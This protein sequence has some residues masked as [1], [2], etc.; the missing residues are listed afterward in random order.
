M[1]KQSILEMIKDREAQ[2]DIEKPILTAADQALM[3]NMI[4]EINEAVG[5]YFRGYSDV[6]DQYIQGAGEIVAKYIFRFED[7]GTRASLLHHLVG[8][9]TYS[10]KPVKDAVEIVWQ[11]YTAYRNSEEFAVW[12]IRMEYDDAFARLRAKKLADRLIESVRN[13]LEFNAL[14]RTVKMLATLMRPELEEILLDALADPGKMEKYLK[15][16]AVREQ[17]RL[18]QQQVEKECRRWSTTSVLKAVVGIRYYPSERALD[19]LRLY[20]SGKQAEMQ[21]KLLSCKTRTER[22]DVQYDYG[23]IQKIVS[24][25]IGQIEHALWSN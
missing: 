16:P 12:T 25:S 4:R 3:Q 2:L 11:L 19:L 7:Q 8:N 13:P 20:E 24:E 15:T 5:G 10:V 22:Y 18:D 1:D 9:K 14:P 17:F 6:V 21:Q 23:N